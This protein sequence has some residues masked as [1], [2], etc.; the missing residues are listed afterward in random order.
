MPAI[1]AR[2]D[3]W[4]GM[5]YVA[6]GLSAL[7]IASGYP[8]GTTARMGP[9]YFP[10]LLGAVLAMF[11]LAAIAR[12]FMRYGE[13]IEPIAWKP[14]ALVTV[15]V[16]AFAWLLPRLGLPLT[17]AVLILISASSSSHFK[18]GIKPMLLMVALIAFCVLLFIEALGVPM[19]LVGSWLKG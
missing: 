5:L 19:P 17:L 13:A 11:G 1:R 6:F 8:M 14:L 3:F 4:A 10:I 18:L 12:S 9:G 16:I 7:A 2:K 15:A